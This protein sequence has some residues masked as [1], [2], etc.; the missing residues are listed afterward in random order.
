[1]DVEELL[2]VVDIQNARIIELE[3]ILLEVRKLVDNA[4]YA[5][6]ARG[7]RETQ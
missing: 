2:K 3:T 6:P 7:D 5:P 1:M 4:A